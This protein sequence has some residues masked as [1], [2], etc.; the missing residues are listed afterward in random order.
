MEIESPNPI[1]QPTPTRT[2]TLTIL[3]IL[4]FVGSGF[5][6]L[7]ALI[8]ALF[9]DEFLNFYSTNDTELYQLMY[10][11]LVILSPGY[12]F[13]EFVFALASL[14]GVILMW[15]LR[16]TGF[17]IYTVANILILSL[18]LFFKV[19]GFNFGN[20]VFFTG[21]FIALYAFQLKTMR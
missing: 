10:D 20:F 21:P 14:A 9:F 1:A 19:G 18:P 17:H 3:C 16:K 8:Y 7:G 13:T 5:S 11:S 4:S 15:K 2:K 12:F 6:I